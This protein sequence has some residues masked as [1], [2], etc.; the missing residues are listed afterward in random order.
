MRANFLAAIRVFSGGG[1]VYVILALTI[2]FITAAAAGLMWQTLDGYREMAAEKQKLAERSVAKGAEAVESILAGLHGR[3]GAFVKGNAL[4][5]EGTVEGERDASLLA[6]RIAAAFPE[7]V[8]FTLL[9]YD[10]RLLSARLGPD[11]TRF[12]MTSR[13]VDKIDL[14]AFLSADGESVQV[15]RDQEKTRISVPKDW[16]HFRTR[17]DNGQKYFRL[18]QVLSFDDGKGVLILGM[19]AN[20]LARAI[21]AHEYFDHSLVLLDVTEKADAGGR[22][23]KRILL[24]PEMVLQKGSGS[25]FMAGVGGGTKLQQARLSE[26]EFQSIAHVQKIPGTN[27]TLAG[28]SH[29]KNFLDAADR[30]RLE[31]FVIVLA[32]IAVLV[33]LL[34]FHRR[35]T[36]RREHAH[37]TLTHAIDRAEDAAEAKGVFL[38][39]MSHELRSPL[40]A[41]MGF[42]E[43]IKDQAFG[44]VQPEY[45]EY[46]ENIHESGAHLLELINDILDMSKVEAGKANLDERVTDV[47][48][49]IDTCM[50]LVSVRAETNGLALETEVREPLPHL[51]ADERKIRQILINL[52]TNAIKF[53]P[54]GGR[55]TTAARLDANGDFLLEVRDTGIGIAPEDIEKALEP[56]GQVASEALRSQQGT[57][58]GLPLTRSFVHLHGGTLKIESTPG[59]RTTVIARFPAVRVIALEQ[60]VVS[61]AG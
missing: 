28:L 50:R 45:R 12:H 11:S 2:A 57:G 23:S 17:P 8:T 10:G 26:K 21:K 32:Y 48:K 15:S 61:F 54:R 44:E 49:V 56:F 52:L 36:K 38:A 59:Q 29:A 47:T 22:K 14:P 31:I 40:N 60:N 13:K 34:W 3:I 33:T 4:S 39:N 58:L 51:Y 7:A 16:M 6:A 46:A 5:L 55:V 24:G 1:V 18:G 43:L 42:S 35:E 30:M 9:G 27:W 53:T 25:G 20:V 37:E 41:I 19:D